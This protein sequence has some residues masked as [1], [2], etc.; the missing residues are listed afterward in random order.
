MSKI[1]RKSSFY[2]ESGSTCLDYKMTPDYKWISKLPKPSSLLYSH[3]LYVT[4]RPFAVLPGLV[5]SLAP[6]TVVGLDTLST[7]QCS[8]RAGWIPSSIVSE[9]DGFAPRWYS[10]LMMPVE[11]LLSKIPTKSYDLNTMF[12]IRMQEKWVSQLPKGR[13]WQNLVARG[14]NRSTGF[15]S[16]CL[17]AEQAI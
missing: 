3:S 10:L 8:Y 11:R 16:P 15:A 2:R 7:F 6:M 9:W 17:L 4:F 1:L 5:S 14:A 13:D 12:H